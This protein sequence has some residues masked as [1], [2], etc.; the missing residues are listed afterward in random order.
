MITTS[1]L[2]DQ[3]YNER[4]SRL[5]QILILNVKTNGLWL[6]ESMAYNEAFTMV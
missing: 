2:Q 4:N 1:L 5:I 6:Q 3:S